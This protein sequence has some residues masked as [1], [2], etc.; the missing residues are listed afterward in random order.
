MAV[1]LFKYLGRTL[2]YSDNDWRA[3]EQKLQKEQVK[4]GTTGEDFGKGGIG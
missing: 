1:P 2:L 4:V 3:V